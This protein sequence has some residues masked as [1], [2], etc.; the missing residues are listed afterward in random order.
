MGPAP[1][2]WCSPQTK[3]IYVKSTSKW[4]SILTSATIPHLYQLKWP[5][6]LNR[7]VKN[8]HIE[9]LTVFH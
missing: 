6:A 8:S 9:I 1:P 4:I 3:Q 5:A 7:S 2:V